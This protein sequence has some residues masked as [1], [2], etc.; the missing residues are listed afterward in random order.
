MGH[1][2][3]KYPF[4]LAFIVGMSIMAIELTASRLLAPFFG[5]SLFVWTN[6]IA[7]IMVALAAGYWLGGKISERKP[8][9][10]NLLKIILLA[11]VIC[12]IIPFATEPLSLLLLK[13]AAFFT[14]S[15]WLILF[16]SFTATLLLFFIPIMLL[17][18]TS[19]YLIKI[20]SIAHPDVGNVSGTIFA[21]STIGSIVGTFLPSLVFIA[22][23]GSK[24]TI[25]F[26]AAVVI[27]TAAI[28]LVKKRSYAYGLF[29]IFAAGPIL[30]PS[31]MRI[32]AATLNET[33]SVY[34]YIQVRESGGVRQLI[35]NEGTGIQS[36]YNPD[37]ILTGHM[38]FDVMAATP[39]LFQKNDIDLLN[40]GLAGGTV[41]RSMAKL[42]EGE[43]NIH[44]DGVEID[45][46]VIDLAKK[47]FDLNIPNLKIHIADG[48]IF[49]RLTEK[50]YDL[51]L[52][53]AYSNQ[54]YI[55]WHLTTDEFFSNINSLLN[56]GGIA[57]L[58]LNATS[59]Q[60]ELY[61]AVT[62]TMA[63][64]FN[65]VYSAPIPNSYNYLI[66]A[67]ND[68]IDFNLFLADGVVADNPGLSELA[69]QIIDNHEHI[70]YNSEIGLLTDDRAPVEHM[71]DKMY[72]QFIV[73][74][75]F[76]KNN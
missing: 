3:Q 25:L 15:S 70:L 6:V 44:V 55:P 28:G 38:Y 24:K 23:I 17:G 36:V 48:R 4:I 46:R 12:F 62:N 35:Y 65:Y 40:I 72:T 73:N 75:I 69:R 57:A 49:A 61:R 53:D 20:I 39:A 14:S 74:Q 33:E 31:S 19:P 13:D 26:F 63:H 10:K 68:P 16:G 21:V 8:D 60:S 71:T 67:S 66:F 5:T 2:K 11:G 7:V 18:M 43:K 52:I 22:W 56:S 29:F 47:Y 32:D 27:I 45:E 41:V 50:K 9:L 76:N 37:D 30:M 54:I 64:N 1:F 34:Q 58:N 51:A 42:F 59:K